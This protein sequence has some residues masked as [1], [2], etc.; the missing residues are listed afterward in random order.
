MVVWKGRGAAANWWDPNNVGL[1]A[2]AAYRAINSV[3]TPWSGGPTAYAQ[4]LVN[5]VTPGVN[6]LVEGNGAVNWVQASGWDFV[7]ANSQYFDT[8]LVPANDQ[9]W[10]MFV[11]FANVINNGVAAGSRGAV[12]RFFFFVYPDDGV[13]RVQYGSGGAGAQGPQLLSGNL[14]VSGTNG[15]RD[16]VSEIVLGVGGANPDSIFIGGLGNVGA[17]LLPITADIESIAIYNGG[18]AAVQAEAASIAAAMAQ[19]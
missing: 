16:G 2:V 7:A 13:N 4:T 14:G 3:G 11:Q 19:L 17:L 5:L 12:P 6:D 1:S 10:S 9:S 15:Y 18:A 8:G